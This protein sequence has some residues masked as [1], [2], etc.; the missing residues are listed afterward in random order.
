MNTSSHAVIV[1]VHTWRGLGPTT[2]QRLETKFYASAPT[3]RSTD[4]PT[5]PSLPPLG[6]SI[7]GR[8]IKQ[9][10]AICLM[11]TR[12]TRES[13]NLVHHVVVAFLANLLKA[14]DHHFSSHHCRPRVSMFRHLHTHTGAVYAASVC[15]HLVPVCV[16]N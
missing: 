7:S 10:A 9:S 4:R 2:N 6:S 15:G 1:A 8:R 14:I 3:D 11:C 13:G 12:F 16:E 5:V